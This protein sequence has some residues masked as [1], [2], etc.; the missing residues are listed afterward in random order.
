MSPNDPTDGNSIRSLL[1]AY[2]VPW[3]SSRRVLTERFGVRPH[4]AYQ[5][6]IIE[7]TTSTPILD[8]LLWGKTSATRLDSHLPAE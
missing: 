2:A 6:D 4:P 3:R 1:D 5:W 8:R 7:L